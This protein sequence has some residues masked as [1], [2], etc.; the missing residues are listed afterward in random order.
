MPH[1]SDALSFERLD[2]GRLRRQLEESREA[3]ELVKELLV[4]LYA[5][6]NYPSSEETDAVLLKVKQLIEE[7]RSEKNR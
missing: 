4:S 1:L 3:S 5:Q 7:R 6:C 2:R